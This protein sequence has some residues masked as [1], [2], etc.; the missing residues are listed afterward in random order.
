MSRCSK[1]VFE[2]LEKKLREHDT[3]LCKIAIFLLWRAETFAR[4]KNREI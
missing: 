2:D 4:T 1:T 3:A